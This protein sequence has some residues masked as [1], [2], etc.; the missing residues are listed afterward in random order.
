MEPG[1][2]GLAQR[3]KNRILPQGPAMRRLPLGIARGC[4]M[5]IDFSRDTRLYAGLYERE[6]N[7][8]LRRLCKPG[9]KCLDIGAFEGYDSLVMGCLGAAEVVAFEYEQGA[10]EA[11]Q[12]NL[13]A[14]SARLPTE[15]TVVQAFI[16]DHSDG[17]QLAI[18]DYLA[19]RPGLV[20]DFVKIDIEGGELLG[21]EGMKTLLSRHRPHLI[22]E[23][24]GLEVEQQCIEALKGHGYDPTVVDAR[25]WLRD[26]RPIGHNRWLVAPGSE[27][28]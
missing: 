28:A 19:E 1:S 27:R 16:S 17:E 18:D 8:W 11:A 6:L 3:V 7:R 23:T 21:V 22:I 9:S 14:N 5:E 13:D 12:R 4:R 20:P 10:A 25:S 26:A 24:H 2:V 15:F